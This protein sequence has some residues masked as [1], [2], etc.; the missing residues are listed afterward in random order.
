MSLKCLFGLL[1]RLKSDPSL[2]KEYNDVI[3]DQLNRG[4]VEMV[5]ETNLSQNHNEVHYIPHH[6]VIRHDKETTKLR[7][8]FDG[9]AKEN[10]PSLN[11][12]LHAGPSLY[13]GILEI[14]LRFRMFLVGLIGD[15]KESIS[16]GVC[17]SRRSRFS[18]FL[19]GG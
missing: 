1:R 9:S 10:G 5:K 11:E 8:V 18:S 17:C 13:Q 14:L 3:T 15:I 19:V 16:H 7:I 6:A 4:I 12:C 2:L